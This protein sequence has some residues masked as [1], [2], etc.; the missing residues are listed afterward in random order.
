MPMTQSQLQEAL[1]LGLEPIAVGVSSRRKPPRPYKPEVTRLRRELD[2]CR[3]NYDEL[4]AVYMDATGIDRTDYAPTRVIDTHGAVVGA[5]IRMPNGGYRAVSKAEADKY[6]LLSPA[7]KRAYQ[8]RYAPTCADAVSGKPPEYYTMVQTPGGISLR[9]ARHLADQW[10]RLT[11]S[12]QRSLLWR[13]TR[14]RGT[15]TRR[16][17]PCL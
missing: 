9:M 6:A 16:E 14:H 2:S 11:P 17:P 5:Y 10:R 7:A 4:A 13:A 1:E 8:K 12:Q 15:V 3:E